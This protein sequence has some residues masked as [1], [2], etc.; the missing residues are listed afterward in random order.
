MVDFYNLDAG[1]MTGIA[2]AVL[3]TLVSWVVVGYM[4]YKSFFVKRDAPTPMADDQID[5]LMR[6]CQRKR[7]RAVSQT[8]SART[9]RFTRWCSGR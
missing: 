4:S 1:V 5:F 3:C 9:V 8:A 2:V 6:R 7:V